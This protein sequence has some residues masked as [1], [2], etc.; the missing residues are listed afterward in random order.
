MLQAHSFL[1]NYLWVAPNVFLLI[2][3]FFIWKRGLSRQLPAFLAFAILSAVGDLA[4]FAADIAPWVSPVNFWRVDWAYLLIES[5][6]KFIVIGEV[7]S[8]LLSPYPS[9]SRLGRVVVTA[10]GSVL[11]LV[12]TLTAVY[13]QGDNKFLLISGFHLLEQTVFIVELGLI[14]FV[15]LFAGYF[16]LSWDRLSFGLL[17]GFGASACEHLAAWAIM[18]N[19]DPSAHGRTLL[20]LL[21]MSAHH[22][23]VLI[24]FYYLLVPG[25][26]AAKTP[27]P[28]PENNLDLWNREL[29]RLL[30][31]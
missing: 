24:W 9:L 20:D 28:L 21:N 26:V 18:T 23:C 11:V 13:S 2:L 31:Q 3:G 5:F 7:F 27:T 15:F 1:W 19:A 16:R 12:A 8:R 14:A 30:Q 22:I 4:V 17:L 29:E 10:F 6:L 25:K